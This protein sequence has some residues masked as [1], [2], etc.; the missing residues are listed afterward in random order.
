MIHDR[1]V[2][3]GFTIVKPAPE[4]DRVLMA[5]ALDPLGRQLVK[6]LLGRA[7][8]GAD[9]ERHHDLQDPDPGR[10]LLVGSDKVTTDKISSAAWESPKDY[11][12]VEL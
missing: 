10:H 7:T 4:L 1:W 8:S 11:Q 12:R 3:S 2:A 9:V 5:G 6:M